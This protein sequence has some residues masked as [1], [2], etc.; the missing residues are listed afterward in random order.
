MVQGKIAEYKNDCDTYINNLRNDT[1]IRLNH[2]QA[3]FVIKKYAEDFERDTRSIQN[4]LKKML[5]KPGYAKEAKLLNAIAGNVY[6]ELA[7]TALHAN[8]IDAAYIL[9]DAFTEDELAQLGME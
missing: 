1:D 4:D 3:F 6:W 5:K 2:P 7:K 8:D 9:L